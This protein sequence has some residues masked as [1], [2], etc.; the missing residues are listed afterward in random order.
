MLGGVPA[1]V[2]GSY[3]IRRV[4]AERFDERIQGRFDWGSPGNGF[5]G[6]DEREK[7]PQPGR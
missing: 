7:E 4:P 5:F 2:L 3:C 6:V 1:Q